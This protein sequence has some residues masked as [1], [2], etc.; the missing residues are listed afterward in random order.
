MSVTLFYCPKCGHYSDRATITVAVLGAVNKHGE[1]WSFFASP[2]VRG[3]PLEDI[4]ESRCRNCG[5]LSELMTLD[6]CPHQWQKLMSDTSCRTCSYCGKIQRGRIVFE[7]IQ[8]KCPMDATMHTDTTANEV[9]Y[10]DT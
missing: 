4:I 1:V 3:I 9:N 8:G 2:P 6:R 5:G 10:A 7:D